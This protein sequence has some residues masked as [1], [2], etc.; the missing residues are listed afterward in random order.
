MCCEENK[1]V[2]RGERMTGCLEGLSPQ[3]AEVIRMWCVTVPLACRMPG[4]GVGV[5]W[6]GPEECSYQS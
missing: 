2:V 1:N 3:E 4:P 5:P 6:E